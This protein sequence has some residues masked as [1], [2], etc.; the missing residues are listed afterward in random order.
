LRLCACFGSYFAAFYR[1]SSTKKIPEMVVAVLW[2]AI[3]T[4]RPTR[5][6]A[7]SAP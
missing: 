4:R 2:P 5:G 3:A 7:R 1:G 6:K